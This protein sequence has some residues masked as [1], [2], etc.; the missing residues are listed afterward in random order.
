MLRVSI[1]S[2]IFFGLLS[3]CGLK[4]VNGELKS[5]SST[6]YMGYVLA[7]HHPTLSELECNTHVSPNSRLNCIE[8]FDEAQRHAVELAERNKLDD[9]ETKIRPDTVAV[10]PTGPF[11]I[12]ADNN[13]ASPAKSNAVRLTA[14]NNRSYNLYLVPLI[15]PLLIEQLLTEP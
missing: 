14:L 2:C 11:S 1:F 7:T 4:S 6:E 8:K 9:K 3:G 15:E 13:T 5:M 12:P 10:A